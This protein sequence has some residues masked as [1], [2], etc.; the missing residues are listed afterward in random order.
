MRSKLK[1]LLQGAGDQTLLSFVDQAV[2]S[3]LHKALLELHYSQELS[4]LYL[5]QDDVDRAQ[6]YIENCIQAFM[7][8]YSSID[9]LL[10]RSRLTKLQS[11]QT[12]IELQEFINFISKQGNLSSQVPLKRLLK[13]WTNRYPDA[14]TDPMTIWDDVITNRCFFLSKIE[15]KLALLPDDADVGVDGGGGPGHQVEKE[16]QSLISSCKFSMKLEMIAGARKQSN[17][18]LAMKL[19]KELHREARTR[20]D[21]LAQ[22][23]QSY[24]QL[25]HSRARAQCP[26]E[27][28][29]TV[30]RTVSLLVVSSSAR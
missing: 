29:C 12:F 8:N 13:T 24:C 21:W 4:L 20:D 7:Q 23:V 16:A 26:S 19:L 27:Q 22:W 3:E 18:S 10:H 6:Y 2:T 15:E 1:L 14:K 11:V 25:S 5:L 17:F 30:L 28:L 9:A